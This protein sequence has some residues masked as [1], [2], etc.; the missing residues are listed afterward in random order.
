MNVLLIDATQS[1]LDYAIHCARHG[2]S[3]RWFLGPLKNGDAPKVG[4]GLDEFEIVPDFKPHLRWAD[5]ILCSDNVKYMHDLTVW[6]KRGLPILAASPE[7]ADLELCRSKGQDSFKSAGLDVMPSTEFTDYDS[8]IE[9]VKKTMKRYVSKP[10]GDADKALSYVSKSPQDMVSMLM[11]WKRL[12]RGREFILQEFVPGIEMA[13]GGWF[14]S[15]GFNEYVLEN[16]EFKK[17]M[18][19]D[20][21]VNTGEQGTAIK[22]VKKG[23]SRLFRETLKK[24]EQQLHGLDYKGFVDISVIVDNEGN[25][26]PLEYTMRPGWPLFNIQ[27]T[28]HPDPVQFLK[29]LVEGRDEFKPYT[30]HAIGV[31]LTI[32]DYPYSHLTNKEVCGYPIY[33]L[34]DD[35]PFRG[36]LHPCELMCAEAPTER[37]GKIVMEKQFVSAGDYL[38]VATGLGKT[39]REAKELAYQACESVEIPNSVGYRTDIGNRL[40][41]QLPILQEHGYATEWE[42]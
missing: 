27:Q 26:R 37:K 13:V 39:V 19:D 23:S 18:N 6:R 29:A 20:L 16:F 2:H 3:V 22:Y 11:R 12:G 25:A 33:F 7:A 34:D 17:M 30:D 32:P 28:V 24:V 4:R 35:N 5:L 1:F 10:D 8:A 42:W 9:F 36:E 41:K 40:K 31:V 38:L 21:G 15:H 14:G